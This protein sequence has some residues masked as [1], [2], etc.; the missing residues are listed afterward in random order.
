MAE[1]ASTPWPTELRVDAERRLLAVTF[2]NGQS[3]ELPAEFLR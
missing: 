1:T 2:D 3:F